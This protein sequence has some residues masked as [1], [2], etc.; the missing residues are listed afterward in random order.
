MVK[1][2][3]LQVLNDVFHYFLPP[4]RRIPPLLWPRLQHELGRFIIQR[5]SNGVIVYFWYHSQFNKVSFPSKCGHFPCSCGHFII[6]PSNEKIWLQFRDNYIV[7]I[8]LNC[9]PLCTY[10]Y[11]NVVHVCSTHA[12]LHC[13]ANIQNNCTLIWPHKNAHSSWP[14]CVCRVILRSCLY[15]LDIIWCCIQGHTS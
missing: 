12:K 3:L 6:S 11:T 5:E 9:S 4:V 14:R 10:M 2:C 15:A 8:S 13:S 7:T 1:K